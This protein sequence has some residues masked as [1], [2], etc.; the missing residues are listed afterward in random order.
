M[1]GNINRGRWLLFVALAFGFHVFYLVFLEWRAL[2]LHLPDN[3][4]LGFSLTPADLNCQWFMPMVFLAASAFQAINFYTTEKRRPNAGEVKNALFGGIAN[5]LGAFLLIR[6]T[7]V[8]TSF[9]HAMLF[10]FFS[11]TLI[12]ICN[13]WGKWLYSE[14]INWRANTCC[15]AGL[16]IGTIDWVGLIK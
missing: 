3:A 14:K 11:V 15:I 7:E 9:E 1:L 5:G 2:L 6:A 16:L 13:L 4:P 8:A 12:V 10:P